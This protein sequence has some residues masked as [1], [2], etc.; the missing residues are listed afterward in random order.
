MAGYNYEKGMSNNAVAAHDDEALFTKNSINKAALIN[1]LI[2]AGYKGKM[3]T[4]KQIKYVLRDGLIRYEEKYHTGGRW[5]NETMF[6]SYETLAEYLNTNPEMQIDEINPPYPVEGY[7]AT[8]GGS[9]SRPKFLGNTEFKGVKKG[10]WIITDDGKCKKA[11]SN[12]ITWG[13]IK[14]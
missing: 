5:Y 8:F 4:L 14:S 3:P 7:Y 13:F 1:G 6:Y 2:A 12:H 10:Y 11:D 9:R